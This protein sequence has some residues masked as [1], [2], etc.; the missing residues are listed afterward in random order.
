LTSEEQN[1]IA[2]AVAAAEKATN[3]NFAVAV[4]RVSDRYRLYPP[5]WGGA[6]AIIGLGIAALARPSLSIT[7]GFTIAA[8]LFVALTLILDW[9]PLRLLIVPK[10]V[11]QRRA[12]QLAHREFAASILANARQNEGV[13]CFVSLGEHFVEILASRAVHAAVAEG[14]WD[15][16]AADLTAAAKAGR[17]SEGMVEAVEACAAAIKIRLPDAKNAPAS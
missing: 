8:A 10:R 13:M 16:I 15:R 1:R 5:V 2:A 17:L 14:T 6:L 11:K 12:D 7:M 4:V 9:L 3:A